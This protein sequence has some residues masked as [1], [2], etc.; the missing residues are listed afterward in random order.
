MGS[1]ADDISEQN[2]DILSYVSEKAREKFKLI[3]PY[4]PE[5]YDVVNKD[6]EFTEINENGAYYKGN[7]NKQTKKKQGFGM[8]AIEESLFEGFF[9]NGKKFGQGRIILPTGDV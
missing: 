1:A 6:E 4:A 2:N 8:L 7:I 3:G 5:G 9:K